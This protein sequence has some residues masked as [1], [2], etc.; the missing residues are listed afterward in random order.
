V[1]RG[2]EQQHQ[3]GQQVQ[4]VSAEQIDAMLDEMLRFTTLQLR[5]SI[6]AEDV[7]HDA[8]SAALAADNF[9]GR[10]NLKSWVFAILRNKIIDVIRDRSRH[11]TES[12]IEEDSGDDQFKKNGH[13]NKSHKPSSWGHPE[14]AL[15]NEQFWVVFDICLKELPENTARVFMMCENIGLEFKEVCNELSFSEVNDWVSMA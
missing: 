8:L 14:T 15:S 9:T 6:L 12:Y 4:K 5:D 7:V 10:G 11:T 1:S 3:I 2:P 13:W